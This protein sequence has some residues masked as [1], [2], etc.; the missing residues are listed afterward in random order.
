MLAGRLGS[1]WRPGD[2][3]DAQG[4]SDLLQPEERGARH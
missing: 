1:S 3:S 2:R 4:L